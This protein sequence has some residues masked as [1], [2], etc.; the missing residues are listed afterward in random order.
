LCNPGFS[1]ALKPGLPASAWLHHLKAQID[2][3]DTTIEIE[4]AALT[5]EQI[6]ES[7]TN[8]SEEDADDVAA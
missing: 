8:G 6:L 2:G 7:L 3:E 4:E 5:E 1:S